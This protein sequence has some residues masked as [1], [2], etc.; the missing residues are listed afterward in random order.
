[1]GMDPVKCAILC[2][3]YKLMGLQTMG[4]TTFCYCG[5]STR[6]AKLAAAEDCNMPCSGNP[7]MNCGAPLRVSVFDLND[8]DSPCWDGQKIRGHDTSKK[9][10]QYRACTSCVAP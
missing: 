5:S 4:T 2:S 9:W 7:G 8:R 3:G 10:H 1:M 6:K